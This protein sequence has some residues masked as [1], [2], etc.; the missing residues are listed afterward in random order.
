MRKAIITL[1]MLLCAVLSVAQVPAAMQVK[2]FTLDNGMTVWLNE[3]HTQPKVYG[4]VVVKAGA[5]DCPGTGIAHYFEHIM[6]KGTDRMGTVDYGAEKPWLDSIAAQYDLLAKATDE[7]RRSEIQQTINR[8][9]LKAADYAI[10]N[11]FNRLIS[12]FG[13]SGLNAATGYDVTYYH[14]TF[15]PQY[16]AQWCWLNSER[17]LHPVFR[18]FQGELENVYEEKNRSADAMG[19]ALEKALKAVFADH[20][21]AE[22]ILGSTESLKNPR[23][24]E[25]E[26]FFK[27][28]YVASNMGLLL[29]GDIHADSLGQLLNNTFGRLPRG[30]QPRRSP[31]AVPPFSPTTVSIKLPI[32]IVKAEALVFRAPTD[33]DPDAEALDLC[34]K[35]LYN[36]KAGYLDSLVNSHELLGAM[37]LR[38][39]FNDA[40]IQA[41]LVIPKLPFGK[42]SKAEKACLQQVERLKRGDFSDEALEQLKRNTLLELEKE[43]ETINGRA[44]LML[45]AYSKGQTWQ[46]V[47]DRLERIRAVGRQDVVRVANKYYAEPYLTLRKKYGME[48]KE[49]LSQPGYKPMSPRNAGAK[50][51]YAKELEQMPVDQKAV[52]VVDF[53]RDAQR[54]ALSPTV[55]LYTTPNPVN[56]IFT[57]TLRFLDGTRHT[58]ALALLANYLSDVGTDSLTKQQVEKAWQQIGT[59]VDY[60]AD[61]KTFSVTLTGRDAYLE[62]ALRLLAHVLKHAKADQDVMRELKQASK[63]QHKSFGKQKDDVMMPL[64]QRIA[65]GGES[66]YLRQVSLKDVKRMKSSDLLLLLKELQQY[67]CE[68][69]YCG[70]QPADDVAALLRQ[71][72]PLSQYSK[73]RADTYRK[74]LPCEQPLVFFYHVPKSRQNL[75]LSYEQLSPAPT[76]EERAVAQLW[77]QYMGSGMSSVL[78]QNVREYRSLAY[79]TQGMSILPSAATHPADSLAFITMTGTQADKTLLVMGTVDSLL[80]HM[81]M[82]EENLEAARQELL[83]DVQNGYP[84]FRGIAHYIADKHLDGYHADPDA[85]LVEHVPAVSVQQIADYH[86][87]HVAGNRRVWM[88]VGDRKQ[89][90]MAALRRYGQVVELK[91]EDIYK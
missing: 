47:L 27:T 36:D 72:L 41:L 82:K 7:A 83:S 29:C 38:L 79:S 22:P 37:A 32:P 52:R 3:D 19:G 78:F 64:L 70:R 51:A 90:D 31:V 43:M 40:G 68:L 10:P 2:V 21:Y 33:Y 54:V 65:F 6:F 80:R 73:P 49:T 48:P 16:V 23:L 53:E 71:H 15:L 81:P 4:A 11:E 74:T 46:R 42:L 56:D 89:T 28:Y 69:L 1:C 63:V 35:L 8:L 76:A 34:N 26:Q 91:K 62:P 39:A 50:S 55:W 85:A 86:R 87:R 75:V 17:L 45:D 9:S 77:S 5:K 13:G 60:K 67:S 14:N 84:S 88:V 61:L 20:P 44:A 24:S 59:D 12:R 25:M 58:P 66:S 18:L 57:L 30:E